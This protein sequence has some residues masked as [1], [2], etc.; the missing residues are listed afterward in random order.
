M[1]VLFINTPCMTSAHFL[2]KIN[3]EEPLPKT[4][5]N[6]K[7]KKKKVKRFTLVKQPSPAPFNPRI[8][9]ENQKF[10]GDEWWWAFCFKTGRNSKARHSLISRKEPHGLRPRN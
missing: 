6:K 7:T 1:I 4:R 10:G 5:L 9:E 2:K 3:K 8:V